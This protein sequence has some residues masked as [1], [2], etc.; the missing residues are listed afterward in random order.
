MSPWNGLWRSRCRR[1]ARSRSTSRTERSRRV[2]STSPMVLSLSANLPT[3]AA[4]TLS[5]CAAS[6]AAASAVVR[7]PSSACITAISTG[8]KRSISGGRV[9]HDVALLPPVGLLH[10]HQ[11]RPQAGRS[12]MGR[13]APPARR[14]R[15]STTS[16]RSPGRSAPTV[17]CRAPGARVPRR[18]SPGSTASRGWVTTRRVT[19]P[20]RTVTLLPAA[21]GH[22][23][24]AGAPPRGAAGR[25]DD[26][27]RPD[28]PAQAPPPR[29]LHRGLRPD[30]DPSAASGTARRR[31]PGECGEAES[32]SPSATS[33]PTR[34]VRL[35]TTAEGRHD[36]GG[37]IPP[38]LLQGQLGL[39]EL[40]ST[41]SESA[42]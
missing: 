12:L 32:E 30:P 27:A 16:T 31:A 7:S 26:R 21:V 28:H 23:C 22:R 2:R 6:A 14:R 8:R 39:A 19:V 34:A 24:R 15:P 38:C 10:Q 1:W 18:R 4:L 36:A 29:S 17:T 41:R 25:V 20:S 11:V 5:P 35:V 3:A 33:R 42:W 9:L 13:S 37:R 40:S